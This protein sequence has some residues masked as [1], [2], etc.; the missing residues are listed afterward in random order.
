MSC[1]ILTPLLDLSKIIGEK[2]FILLQSFPF[3]IFII[4]LIFRKQIALKI[5]DMSHANIAGHSLDFQ[6]K[7]QD[8]I[9]TQEVSKNYDELTKLIASNPK[10]AKDE[11]LKLTTH[12]HYERTF[13]LIFGTQIM[14]LEKLEKS[15]PNGQPYEDLRIFWLESCRLFKNDSYGYEQ[16][17][18]FLKTALLITYNNKNIVLST[19]GKDFLNYIRN[20]YPVTYASKFG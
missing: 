5:S 14:L 12:L 8:N 7:A 10:N 9:A 18:G 1:I 4:V 20:Y 2:I 15:V 19:G 16:Y 6:K 3:I 13:N 11:Y 17:I